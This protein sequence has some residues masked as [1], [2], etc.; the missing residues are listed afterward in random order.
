MAKIR[1]KIPDSLQFRLLS[2]LR[3]I[4]VNHF[5]LD[6]QPDMGRLFPILRKKAVPSSF[7]FTPCLFDQ[8][9]LEH[10]GTLKAS[11]RCVARRS[12]EASV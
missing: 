5:D 8:C 12:F 2:R 9:W 6:G 10:Q 4:V 1:T 3:N 7:Q 11:L